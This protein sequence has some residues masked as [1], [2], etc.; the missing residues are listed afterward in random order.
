MDSI[1]FRLHEEQ[2]PEFGG[3]IKPC[4]YF[5]LI[6]GTSTGGLIAL[7]LGRLKMVIS[8]PKRTLICIDCARVYY[9]IYL[10][11]PGGF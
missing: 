11:L 10:N 8:S 1:E 4:D 6:C 3:S 2:G 9:S 7:M 5:D